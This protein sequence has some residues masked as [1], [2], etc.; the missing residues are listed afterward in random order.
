M[1]VSPAKHSYVWLPRKCDY[2][3]DGQTDGQSDPYVSLCFAGDT[4]TMWDKD[5]IL[6]MYIPCEKVVAIFLHHV[7]IKCALATSIVT[8]TSM[9]DITIIAAALIAYPIKF[10]NFPTKLIKY[11]HNLIEIYIYPT[12][13]KFLYFHWLKLH[14]W[15]PSDFLI[16]GAGFFI[17]GSG[18]GLRRRFGGGQSKMADDELV[19]MDLSWGFSFCTDF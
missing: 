19:A 11:V 2:C 17:P 7:A 3:T 18:S 4:K 15:T 6:H 14:T 9:T 16:P 5:F 1:H 12:S 13:D 10:P 8:L